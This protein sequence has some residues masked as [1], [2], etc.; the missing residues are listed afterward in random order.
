MHLRIEV[1]MSN[2]AFVEDPLGELVRVLSTVVNKVR[3]QRDRDPRCICDAPEI[4]DVLKDVNGNTVG[5]IKLL[6]ADNEHG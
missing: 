5:S 3:N 6:E 4:D 1:D 2:D